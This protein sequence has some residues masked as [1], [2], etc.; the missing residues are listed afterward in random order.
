MSEEKLRQDLM[1]QKL[2][3]AVI[4]NVTQ[5]QE[6]RKALHEAR[7]KCIEA[8]ENLKSRECALTLKGIP[9]K[10]KED[11]EA[12]LYA[13]T[14]E[15]RDI[16]QDNEKSERIAALNL[17]LSLDARRSLENIVKLT[18]AENGL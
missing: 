9:G 13:D 10:N 6:R 4:E 12:Y 7:E 18:E 16:L 8:K 2:Q 11:R 15:L 1:D 14:S 3:E 5:I 17:E